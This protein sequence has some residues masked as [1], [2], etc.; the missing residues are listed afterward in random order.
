MGSAERTLC[1]VCDVKQSKARAK[2]RPSHCTTGEDVT[3]LCISGI[4]V[5]GQEKT[6]LGAG[7][8]RQGIVENW[9]QMHKR[10]VAPAPAGRSSP[11][12]LAQSPPS[13]AD[14]RGKLR[15]VAWVICFG[16]QGPGVDHCPPGRVRQSD[17]DGAIAKKVVGASLRLHVVRSTTSFG[18]AEARFYTASHRGSIDGSR[19]TQSGRPSEA[20]ADGSAG[21]SSPPEQARTTTSSQALTYTCRH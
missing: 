12:P 1:S 11:C 9:S 16:V 18:D 2:G 10:Y 20:A 3:G 15:S 14:G 5:E 19:Q 17:A 13:A 21:R 4:C 8:F 7:T 6:D